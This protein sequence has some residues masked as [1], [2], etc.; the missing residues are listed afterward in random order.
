MFFTTTAVDALP[1][2][3]VVLAYPYPDFSGPSIFYQP[4]HGMMLDQTV[5]GM[6]FKLIG[7]YGWCPARAGVHGTTR[8]APLR[9]KSVEATFDSAFYGTALP[10]NAHAVPDLRVFLRKFEVQSVIVLPQGSNPGLIVSDVTAAIGCPIES[11]GLA[12]WTDVKRRLQGY[13]AHAVNASIDACG[14]LAKDVTSILT[15]GNGATL[16]GTKTLDSKASGYF[17]VTKV[18]FT[19]RGDPNITRLSLMAASLPSDGSLAGM[20]PA[21]PMGRTRCRVLASALRAA[22]ALE[23][24]SPSPSRTKTV[25][26]G[27]IFVTGTW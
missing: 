13:Q 7:G 18:Q 24:P 2:G 19:S 1:Q 4:T 16:S 11:D 26:V 3:G 12:I 21:F 22:A 17:T 6:R 15:P 8:P 23:L 5:A 25:Y 14:A 10:R 20:R 27:C 9:P